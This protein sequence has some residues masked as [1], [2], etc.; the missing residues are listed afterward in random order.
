MSITYSYVT[1]WYFYDETKSRQ[2]VLDKSAKRNIFLQRKKLS[3]K[4]HGKNDLN[5]GLCNFR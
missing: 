4:M 5:I 1:L 2:A 3:K